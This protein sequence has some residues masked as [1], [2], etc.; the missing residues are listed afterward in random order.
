M[1]IPEISSYLPPF[2][3]QNRPLQN[4]LVQLPAAPQVNPAL[5][6]KREVEY[7]DGQAGAT[8]V[9]LGPNSS[10]LYLDRGA[11]ILWVVA[12]DQNG[13]KSL[14]KGY[15]IGDEYVSPKPVTMDDLMAEMKTLNDRLNKMEEKQHGQPYSRPAGQNKSNGAGNA[16]GQRN[17]TADSAGNTN[18]NAQPG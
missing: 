17:G 15:W 9:P 1:A 13:S 8:G 18:G 3:S 11:N 5:L 10:G 12:T 14:V 4:P 16:A 2:A 7:V 6:P